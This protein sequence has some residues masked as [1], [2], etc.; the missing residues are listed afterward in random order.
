MKWEKIGVVGIDSG[1]LI[2]GDP[3]YWLKDADYNKLFPIDGEWTY[4]TRQLKYDKGHD[5]KGVITTTGY[6]DGEYPVYVKYNKEGRV[7]EIRV[8]FMGT[9]TEKAFKAM[10]K[11][12]KRAA[13]KVGKGGIHE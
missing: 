3:C 7:A 12:V 5:G 11:K 9:Y 13:I 6:G 2:L 10:T 1:N 8:K 4:Q